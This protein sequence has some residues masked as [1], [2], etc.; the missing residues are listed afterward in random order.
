MN[1]NKTI[2]ETREAKQSTNY[3]D[4]FKSDGQWSGHF[5]LSNNKNKNKEGKSILPK[6]NFHQLSDTKK[7]PTPLDH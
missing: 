7:C 4:V 6:V 1:G 5:L 3:H 2:K